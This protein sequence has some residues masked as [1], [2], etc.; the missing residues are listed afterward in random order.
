MK[1]SSGG[2]EYIAVLR[3]GLWELSR[4]CNPVDAGAPILETPAMVKYDGAAGS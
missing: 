3:K 4:T 2:R 1:L